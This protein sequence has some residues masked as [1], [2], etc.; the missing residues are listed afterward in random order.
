MNKNNYPL[1]KKSLMIAALSASL[2]YPFAIASTTSSTGTSSGLT[3]SEISSQPNLMI[4]LSNSAS[5]DKNMLGTHDA[6]STNSSGDVVPVENSCPA[7]YSSSSDYLPAPTFNDGACGGTGSPFPYGTYGN[8]PDSRFYIAKQALY[9]ILTS[10]VAQNINLGFATYRQAFGL[11]ASTVA[12]S[13][14]AI[15]PNIYL[16]KQLGGESSTFPSPY[17]TYTQTQLSNVA[18]N[19]LNFSFVSWWPIYNATYV[20]SNNDGNALLGN[21]LNGSPAGSNGA[22]PFSSGGLFSPATNFLKNPT[23]GGL[24]YDVSYPAGTIQNTNVSSG[25]YEYS[26]YGGGGLTPQEAAQSPQPPEPV[27]Q[28]CET[29]Y[30][31]Q[32]NTFQAIYTS[33]AANGDPL[34]FQQSFPSEYNAN[35][36]YYVTPSSPLFQNGSITNQEYEQACNVA[37][38]P[39]GSAAPTEQEVAS[40][41]TLASNTWT[42]PDGVSENA[43]FSYIPDWDS[44]TSDNGS[45]LDLNPGAADGWSGATTV[46]SS[47]GISADYPATP[48]SESILGAWDASGSKWM[49]AFVNLPS[50][51]DVKNN[52]PVIAAMVNPAYPMENQDGLEYSHSTQTI[53]NSAGDLRSIADSSMSG[54]Y[55]G[56]QEPLYDS[57]QDAYAYWQAFENNEQGGS[58]SSAGCYHN[59]MLVIFDG[60]SDGHTG[61]TAAQEQTALINEAKALYQNLGVKIYVIII[62]DNSG[63]ITQANDLAAAGGTQDAFQVTNSSE[64]ASALQSTFVS[65]ASE[66]LISSFTAPSSIQSGDYE[67]APIEVSQTGGEGD[68]EAYQVLSSGNLNSTSSLTPSWDSESLLSGLGDIPVQTTNIPAVTPYLSGAETTLPDLANSATASTLF[69]TTSSTPSPA[70]IADYTE[71]PSYD[72]GAYLGGRTSGW[73]VGLPSGSKPVV[74]TPPDNGNLMDDAGYQAFAS[75]HSNRSNAVLY[76]GQDGLLTAVNYTNGPTPAPSILWSWMP[77]AFIP[78]LQNYQSFWKSQYMAGGFT[79]LDASNGAASPTWHSYVVGS[80]ENGQVLYDLQLSGTASANL[81]NTVAEYDLPSNTSQVTAGKPEIT[82]NSSGQAFAAWSQNISGGGSQIA[83]MNVSNGALVDIESPDTLTSMPIFGDGGNLY[84][85]AGD[86]ILEI[87]ASNLSTLEGDAATGT[88]PPTVTSSSYWTA[89]SSGTSTDMMPFSGSVNTNIQWLQESYNQGSY[90][91]TAESSSGISAIQENNG[92]WTVEWVSATSGDARNGSSGLTAQSTN[93]TASNAIPTLPTNGV[94][95]DAALVAGGNVYL[96]VS[97]PPAGD[98]C[99]LSTAYYYLYSLSTGAFPSGAVTDLNGNAIT[100][101]LNVGYGTALTPSLSFMNGKD[102]LQGASSNTNSTQVFPAITNSG[103]PVGGPVSW[104]LVVPY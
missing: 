64:L 60:I 23:Q 70:T 58:S 87:T 100:G 89:L 104:K 61:D 34:L 69:G 48:Q 8:L 28:L 24:P 39:S 31:S 13:S 30:N 62:S 63:D 96:P 46:N 5:M 80:A 10:N 66:S 6:T 41:E 76:S 78:E 51:N 94:V 56:N 12:Q 33:N 29:F 38:T 68:L 95:T 42:L 103:L 81:S 59:N 54:S 36:L 55:D 16:P 40:G 21:G 26:Y 1:L 72:G 49:G 57:L 27:L 32:A 45:S 98:S 75:G 102:I 92:A 11:E 86:Q 22:P 83:L 17:N 93:D 88:T 7:N 18:N 74:V 3:A 101:P 82:W 85:G 37:T 53:K 91:L 65:V 47:G 15:Y 99:G 73:F 44:G 4:L 52:A 79:E 43:Y 67:F 25:T 90:W 20:G 77:S 14:N 71:N 84:V 97:V 9:N 50:S 2:A 19:P 35:T